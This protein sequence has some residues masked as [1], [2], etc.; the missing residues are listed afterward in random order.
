MMEM[1]VPRLPRFRFGLGGFGLGGLTLG[2]RSAA[3][4][5]VIL[6]FAGAASAQKKPKE[7]TTSRTVQG[8]VFD[9]D[10]KPAPGGVVQLKDMR[11]L[12]VRSFIAQ[13][14]GSYHFSNLKTDTDYQLKAEL[15]GMMSGTKTLSVFDNRK[16]AIINLK[17]EKK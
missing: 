7:D 15:N 3:I 17:L 6:V 16:I 10:D 1:P 8:T 2:I 4:L 12:Q 14:D 11:T 13:D 9:P 5:A